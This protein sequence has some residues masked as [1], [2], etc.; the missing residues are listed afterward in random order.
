MSNTKNTTIQFSEGDVVRIKDGVTT[1]A[2]GKNMASWVPQSK[3]YVRGFKDNDKVIIS[4]LQ[5]GDVTGTVF[6]TDLI[7]IESVSKPEAKPD[8]TVSAGSEDDE[9]KIWDF[10][11]KEIG[12]EYGTAGLM[13]NLHYESGL[14]SN[15][16]QNSGNNRIGMTDEEYTRAVDNGTYTNFVND[17]KLGC[18]Y[19]LAQWTY[20]SRKQWLYEYAKSKG[21]SIGDLIM[22][23]EFLVMELKRDFKTVWNTLCN[24]Q[25]VKEASDIVL[26]KFEMPADLG[27][28]KN[29]ERS[30]KR[31]A[32]GQVYYD[33]Y[34]KTIVNNNETSKEEIKEETK[35]P[36][37][38]STAN[39]ECSVPPVVT[40]PVDAPIKEDS[41]S[42][43]N[44]EPNYIETPDEARSF[45]VRLLNHIIDFIVHL[46]KK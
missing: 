9:K 15:N 19:G 26:N 42:E 5:S 8:S 33:K 39:E 37:N 29:K 12:N 40:P 23:L 45:F 41:E 28:E 17:G 6:A 10:L 46:F 32:K 35:E 14:R 43:D 16:L 34:H 22:Q 30:E 20:W 25:S 36:Q 1:F 38:D 7:L 18:G 2:N 13:D 3:L 44:K 27:E 11:V 31:A 21:V 24:A 4:T